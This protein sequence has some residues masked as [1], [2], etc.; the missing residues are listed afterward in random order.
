MMINL[1]TVRQIFIQEIVVCMR[2]ERVK[3]TLRQNEQ[4]IF[5]TSSKYAQNFAAFPQNTWKTQISYIFTVKLSNVW[6]GRQP[7]PLYQR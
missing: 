3:K 7:S 6:L 2:A 4:P 1:T 5:K